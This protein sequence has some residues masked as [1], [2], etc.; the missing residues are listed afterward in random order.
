MTTESTQN[1]DGLVANR[2]VGIALAPLAPVTALL[3]G[4]NV[5]V[6]LFASVLFVALAL[7][8]SRVALTA[9]PLVLSVSLI[10]HCI[11]LTAAFAGHAWQLDSHMLFFAVLAIIATMG[12][13]TAVVLAVV[14]TA[15]HH[16]GFG[17]LA[18]LLVYPETSVVALLLRTAMHAAIVVFEAAV[19]IWT[20]MQ[21]AHAKAEMLAAREE[22]AEAARTAEAAQV[23]AEKTR[24]RAVI[25]AARTR[26]QGQRAAAALE[27]IAA[28]ARA[29]T[30]SAAHASALV[31]R[32]GREGEK[33]SAVVTTATTAMNAIEQS[34]VQIG[35]IV[36]VIDEIARQTDLLALNAAVESARAG[37]AGRGFAVVANEV[38]K[39][40]Q[41][42]ADAAQQIRSLVTTSSARVVE[43]VGLVDETG[44]AL[45]RIV[46]AIAELDT[47]IGSIASGATDQS[48]DLTQVTQVI[49]R[50]DQ[51]SETEDTDVA[52]RQHPTSQRAMSRRQAA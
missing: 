48:R 8:S 49:T 47:V 24:E 31:A 19:L 2:L 45:G 7:A 41:R 5:W 37:D 28:T 38:R 36:T 33:S 44:R 32:T 22:L 4:G 27:Q 42:S 10:G 18:P 14:I 34:S 51:F 1:F 52:P 50:L 40:A 39:L 12:S 30:E 20:M 6:P 23:E 21:S 11:A 43:G 26:E 29:A 46:A 17:L 13:I 15:V 3:V 16:L 35:Q 25:A 9:R